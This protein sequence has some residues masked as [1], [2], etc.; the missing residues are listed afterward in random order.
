[1]Q[2]FFPIKV[3]VESINLYLDLMDTGIV[4]DIIIA[5]FPGGGEIF[6]MMYIV[7]Y[8]HSKGLTVITVAMMCHR[9]IKIDGW[10]WHRILCIPVHRGNNISVYQMIELAIKK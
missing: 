7:T 1:M 3:C 6:V 8:A 2:I 10:S 9:E 5:G 4:N